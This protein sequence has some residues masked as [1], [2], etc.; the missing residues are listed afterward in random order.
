MEKKGHENAFV[1]RI[2]REESVAAP[3]NWRG[4]VQHVRSGK[5]LYFRDVERLLQ[6]VEARTGRLP[7]PG[8]RR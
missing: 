3:H 4:W 8:N 7:A 2:W 6:F 5:T 1:I